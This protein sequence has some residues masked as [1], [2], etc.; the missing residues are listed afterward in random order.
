MPQ[1][2]PEFMHLDLFKLTWTGWLLLLLALATVLGV[3]AVI[4]LTLD[5]LGYRVDSSSGRGVKGTIFIIALAAAAGV[6]ELGRRWLDRIGLP[7][8]RD[9]QPPARRVRSASSDR[10]R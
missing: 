7:I 5:T 10:D 3:G 2:L 6:F 1:K 8:L 9:K 4:I